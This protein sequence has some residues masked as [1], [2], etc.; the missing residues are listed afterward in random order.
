MNTIHH[1]LKH[2]WNIIGVYKHTYLYTHICFCVC[3]LPVFV[4]TFPICSTEEELSLQHNLIIP[5][6]T[7][8]SHERKWITQSVRLNIVMQWCSATFFQKRVLWEWIK[9]ALKKLNALKKIFHL[10]A[11]H[12]V[13]FKVQT[14][15]ASL[16]ESTHWSQE[17]IWPSHTQP[18]NLA[19]TACHLLCS[20]GLPWLPEKN[21]SDGKSKEPWPAHGVN[22]ALQKDMF[23]NSWTLNTI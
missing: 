13:V 8:H 7:S 17:E 3:A 5:Q 4:H 21:A 11:I 2:T 19:I 20:S 16:S 23:T 1:K 9:N 18:S 15:K 12:Q 10:Y 22:P 6:R 14:L